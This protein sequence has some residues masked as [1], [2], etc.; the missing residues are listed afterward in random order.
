MTRII[1]SLGSIK[2]PPLA[3][4]E[5]AAFELEVQRAIHCATGAYTWNITVKVKKKFCKSETLVDHDSFKN[6]R[7]R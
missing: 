3:G 1:H 2:K 4:I 7:A 6:N 5:P